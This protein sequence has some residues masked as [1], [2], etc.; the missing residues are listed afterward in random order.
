MTVGLVRNDRKSGLKSGGFVIIRFMRD[1][2]LYIPII[3]FL[4]FMSFMTI[5]RI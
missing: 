2:S 4:Y 3:I 5:K 1:I